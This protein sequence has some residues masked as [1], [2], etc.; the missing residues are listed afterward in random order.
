MSDTLPSLEGYARGER[1]MIA[2][3]TD[4]KLAVA[5]FVLL[6]SAVAAWVSGVSD[7]PNKVEQHEMRIRNVESDTKVIRESQIRTEE[8]LRYLREGF[9]RME[10]RHER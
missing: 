5:I 9:E 3:L 1:K 6:I 10:R 8:N 4:N 2:K 7:L